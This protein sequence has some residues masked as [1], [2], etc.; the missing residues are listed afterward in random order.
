MTALTATR[1]TVSR[2]LGRKR[3]YPAAAVQAYGGGLC[4]IGSD[5][6]ATPATAAVTNNSCPG[7]Y[8]ADFNNSSGSVGDID[9]T[10]QE[11]EFLFVG[12]SVVQGNVGERLYASDDQTVDET[13]GSNEPQAGIMTQFV[14]TTSCWLDVSMTNSKV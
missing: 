14:S 13:Q 3:S 10:V 4:M 11:G 8:T 6:Y 5:G 12:T 2:N 7:V 9:I 1:L